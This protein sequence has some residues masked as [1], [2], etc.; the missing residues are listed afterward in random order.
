VYNGAGVAASVLAK[1]DLTNVSN[2]DFLAKA[3][4][5]GFS[6]GVQAGLAGRIAYYPSTGS[7][8]NDLSEVYWHTHDGTSMLH[9]NGELEVSGQKNKIRFHW[10]SLADLTSQVPAT[11]WHGMVAHAHDTG[12]LYYAHAGAWV[13][14]AS[15]DMVAALGVNYQ[16]SVAA[17]DSTQR[18]IS[19]DEVIKFTGAGG[20]TTSSDAEGAITI[21]GAAVTGSVTFVGTTIDSVDSSA[22]TFTPSV[23][24]DS[25]ITVGT[26]IVFPDGSRQSTSAVGIPGPK[27]DQ[28]E[29]G[30]SGSGSGDV[31]SAGGSYVDNR[32]VRYDGTT[33]TIIQVS[34][35][36]ISDAGLLTA[37]SFSGVGSLITAL[38]A[39]ELTSGTIP[40]ARFPATLPAASG[41][42]L[43]A[44][45]ATQLTSGT[46]P[47]ARFPAT[48]PATSGENLTA[49]NATQL[50]SGTI[51]DARF[52]ATLPAASGANLTALNA[53][54]LTSGTVPIGRIGATGTPS[55]STYLRGDNS[56]AT[57]SGGAASDSFATI[58]V[59]GQ[60]SVAADSATDTLTLV[61]GTNITITTDA[62][63][64]SITINSTASGGAT[65]DSFATIAVAG[66][67]SVVADSGTDTLTLVAGTGI[68]ITTNAGSDT[69]T[70]TNSVS[71]GATA[72]TGLSDRSDLTVDQFYLQA[73][74]RLAVTANGSSA[75]RFDQY[76]TTDNPTIYAISGTTIAFDL[77]VGLGSHPFLI[78][79]SG[80]NY[81]TG[82]V[83]VTSA[84]VVTTGSSAQGK[85]SGTLYWKIP[86]SIS[87]DYGY[88][89]SN[90]GSMAG[91]ITIKAI[92]A[93][94]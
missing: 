93:I 87:G 20:I 59:A 35:A 84:G 41:V 43:T 60:S 8:V 71:A 64:D 46:V 69:I 32:I 67:S 66:Q 10:D 90:H 77:S 40:D 26:D 22:I 25:D 65:S 82:L 4:A 3:T 57:V 6:G 5:A 78:R 81:S 80:S 47:D 63:T 37:T 51:P 11:D 61:A 17:D 52:P 86:A 53:T 44:I 85:T 50:T 16:F 29:P 72:F 14:V 21:S 45:N 76:S 15:E 94:P 7:Q 28:G 48:L 58:A 33:G 31:L 39:T 27:G 9:V 55:A 73:I 83:H 56:W 18:V 88:L 30:A 1:S 24:F 23:V 36:S 89:C 68:S 42:N 34:S 12:K 74:T 2:P 70:I 92:S 54:Q 62:A 38:N 49:L 79:F 75:Y 19:T 91:T 13:A